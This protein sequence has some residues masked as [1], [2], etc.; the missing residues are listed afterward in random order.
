MIIL[1]ISREISLQQIEINK[2]WE[3]FYENIQNFKIYTNSSLNRKVEL[4]D[5]VATIYRDNTILLDNVDKLVTMYTNYSENKTI[6][7]HQLPL[8]L[9]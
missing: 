5:I 8:F 1:I 6:L 7:G 2:L 9:S 4:E 3:N